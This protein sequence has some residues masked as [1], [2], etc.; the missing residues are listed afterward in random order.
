MERRGRCCAASEPRYG[1]SSPS[2]CNRSPH[3][4]AP[5]AVP[6]ISGEV[7]RNEDRG[8]M[9]GRDRELARLDDALSRAADGHG[10]TIVIGGEAGIGKTRLVTALEANAR[11]QGFTVLNGACL[12]AAGGAVPFAPYVEWLR[13][14]TKSMD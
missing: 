11:Q 7:V 6:I 1:R 3:D 5:A 4:V 13:G 14:L 10:R 12:P 2:R 9:V 8:A